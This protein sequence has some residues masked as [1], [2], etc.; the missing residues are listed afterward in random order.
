M[1]KHNSIIKNLRNDLLNTQNITNTDTADNA[2]NQNEEQNSTPV[3]TDAK[4]PKSEETKVEPPQEPKNTTEKPATRKPQD[5]LKANSSLEVKDIEFFI[6][7]VKDWKRSVGSGKRNPIV[8][9]ESLN[10]YLG[11]V[12]VATGIPAV[13]FV[14]Y[15][16]THFLKSN[17]DFVAYVN[18][19]TGINP[20][21][22][23]LNE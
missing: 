4:E 15:V 3:N 13:Q 21:L 19:K 18:K 14:N 16:V 11:I 9:D 12:K 7:G 6:K 8:L 23:E 5:N 22:E 1:K 10:N 2:S 20:F 17:P